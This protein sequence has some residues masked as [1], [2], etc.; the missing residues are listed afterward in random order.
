MEQIFGIEKSKLNQFVTRELKKRLD[1][2]KI[3]FG[4]FILFFVIIS[5][6][7]KVYFILLIGLPVFGLVF[8]YISAIFKGDLKSLAIA[9]KYVLDENSISRHVDWT[10]LSS[11]Q[12]I[13]A[14]RAS[15]KYG[16]NLEQR[17]DW[18]DLDSIK[19]KD[20]EV[21]II[22]NKANPINGNGIIVVPCE[23]EMFNQVVQYFS[24]NKSK[25]KNVEL[26]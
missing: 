21:K 17:I 22:S 13:R 1:K 15:Y 26:D 9:F 10:K 18:I 8:L 2:V 4:T 25:F 12:K 16:E 19:I 23:I 11:S 3:L 5:I 24:S 6:V 7:T 20:T 14:E